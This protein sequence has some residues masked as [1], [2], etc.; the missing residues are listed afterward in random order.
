MD[1]LAGGRQATLG[2]NGGR[3][4]LTERDKDWKGIGIEVNTRAREEGQSTGGRPEHGRKARAR[5]ESRKDLGGKNMLE[6]I[7]H[8]ESGGYANQIW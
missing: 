3:D 2:E 5:E 4:G 7:Y 8:F 1:T 6:L